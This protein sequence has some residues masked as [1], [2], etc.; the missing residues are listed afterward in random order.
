MILWRVD[1]AGVSHRLVDAET[2]E[3]AIAAVAAELLDA[4]NLRAAAVDAGT[5]HL[6][7]GLSAA[8]KRTFIASMDGL[9]SPRIRGSRRAGR[10]RRGALVE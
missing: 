6:Y 9:A 3:E 1:V 8:R 5:Q 7:E 2:K 4:V 10:R